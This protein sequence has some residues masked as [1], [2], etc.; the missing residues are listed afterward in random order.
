MEPF[1]ISLTFIRVQGE[2]K[3]DGTGILFVCTEEKSPWE[4]KVKKCC[5]IFECLF[6]DFFWILLDMCFLSRTLRLFPNRLCPREKVVFFFSFLSSLAFFPCCHKRFQTGLCLFWHGQALLSV[7]SPL[8]TSLCSLKT[9][10]CNKIWS[11]MQLCHAPQADGIHKICTVIISSS[12]AQLYICTQSIFYPS[13][14]VFSQCLSKHL[15]EQR[16]VGE[17]VGCP[18]LLLIL[19]PSVW[20]LKT[21]S[22]TQS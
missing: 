18:S 21:T 7:T 12:Y 20:A 16:H 6:I 19:E 2:E 4:F 5:Q 1:E 14:E 11:N 17:V 8:G 22:N 15:L 10:G 3:K 13:N 9:S